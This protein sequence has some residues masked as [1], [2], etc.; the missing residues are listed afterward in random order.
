MVAESMKELELYVH[1]PFCVQKCFYCDFLSAPAD[2]K[3][4]DAYMEALL[5]EIAGRA[6][7]CASYR[8]VSVFIGGGT[9]SV[10]EATWIVRLM[11]CI[12]QHYQLTDDVEITMEMNPGT[13]TVQ[14]LQAYRDAGINRLSIG[15]QSSDDEML[16]R[17]GRIH[18]WDQFRQSFSW[19][20]EVGFE[21]INVDLMSGLPGQMPEEFRQTLCQVCT[22]PDPPQHIS[23]YGLMVEPNTR[24]AGQLEEGLF[25][26]PQEETDR[27][28]YE[29]T[30]QILQSYGYHRYEIS[31]YART[32]F[33]CRHNVGY[34]T[35]VSYL[36]FGL[37]AASLM[38]ER[39]LQNTSDLADY[40]DNPL[41]CCWEVE[42]LDQKGQMEEFCFLRL[43]MST[44]ISENDF[45]DRF[46]RT[47][48]SVYQA[49]LEQN[50]RDGLLTVSADEQSGRRWILTDKGLHLA[51]YVMAQF[52]LD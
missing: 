49:V 25:C 30:G 48:Q 29:E 15:L 12:R 28:M 14:S 50:E 40:V 27:Q 4:Q 38:E 47:L 16:H 39:R 3:T 44:G 5:W 33:A 7:S 13:V 46:G 17:I 31:N 23:V 1:I 34:W 36:G 42:V 8:V 45:W 51:N 20:R 26:L 21:N 10:V 2:K 9:P 35:R 6:L 32:G 11:D 19:A 18:T 37:G 24:L 41:D 52:L 43:R 22:L